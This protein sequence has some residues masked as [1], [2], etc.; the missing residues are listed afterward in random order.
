MPEP[1]DTDLLTSW[2]DLGS[3]PAFRALVDRYAGLVYMAARRTCADEAMAKEA[4]QLSFIT[5]AR[6]AGSLRT[7]DSIGSWLHVTAIMQAKNLL[8]LQKREARKRE[9][10]GTHLESSMSPDEP[11]T[12]WKNLEPVLDQ[13][14]ASLSESDREAILLRHYRTLSVREVADSLRISVDAA[15]KRLDRAME[16]LR[17]QLAR[18]GYATGSALGAAVLAGL[19]TDARA[20][21]PLASSFASSA[22]SAG[23]AAGLAALTTFILTLMTKKITIAAVILLALGAIALKQT[24]KASPPPSAAAAA[25]PAGGLKPAANPGGTVSTA[26][27]ENR[28]LGEKYG[29]ERVRLSQSVADQAIQVSTRVASFMDQIVATMESGDMPMAEIDPAWGLTEEQKGKLASLSVDFMKRKMAFKKEAVERLVNN[30]L[31]VVEMLLAGDAC[32]RGEATLEEYEERRAAVGT[33]LAVLENPVDIESLTMQFATDLP[34]DDET[35]MNGLRALVDSAQVEALVE[36]MKKMVPPDLGEAS[37]K[38]K[39][40]NFATMPPAD[41]VQLGKKVDGTLKMLEGLLEQIQGMQESSPGE[42][43]P[44]E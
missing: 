21:E 39:S 40:S 28:R 42:A 11:S 32:I 30:P 12:L 44:G 10:L 31:P 23:P 41:L 43:E 14:L 25:S 29:V 24:Y 13:A 8:Q 2:L 5:L 1:S 7:R 33:D 6:K 27:G 18:R 26:A 4:S 35:Y 22:L 38:K 34:F 20:G 3:E 17:H 36:E 37:E 16:R 15:Q 19:S 9:R